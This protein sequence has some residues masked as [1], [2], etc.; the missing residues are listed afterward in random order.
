VRDLSAE[1]LREFHRQ[2][3]AGSSSILAIFGD[4]DEAKVEQ[5]VGEL[6]ADLPAR[7]APPLAPPSPGIVNPGEVFVKA[8]GPQ[9]QVAGVALAYPSVSFTQ[10]PDRMALT[11]LDTIISGYGLPSGWL[12]TALRGGTSKYV[13]EV[14]AMNWN[15]LKGG[16]FPAYAGT[17]PEQVNKVVSIMLDL[18]DKAREGTFTEE[19]LERSKGVILTSQLLDRQ[20]N[21]ERATQAALDE[22]YG[23]GYDFSDTLPEVIDGISMRDVQDV[24]RRYLGQQ[25]VIVVVTP[26]PDAVD[27]PDFEKKVEAA[28]TQ[29][30]TAAP[31]ARR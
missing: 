18:V 17:Q 27:I 30:A 28:Q 26:D 11:V 2:H 19:E 21:A 8:K 3:L 31:A 9:R 14:H 7:E 4:I 15:G 5:Q 6:F 25:P 13:Y 23:L 10:V 12:H 16:F 1:D 24:A 29:R 22:L 20:T